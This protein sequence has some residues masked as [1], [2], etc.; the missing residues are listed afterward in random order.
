MGLLSTEYVKA[1]SI[2][3]PDTICLVSPAQELL[4]EFRFII[5]AGE[6]IDGSEYRWDNVLDIRHDWPADC[7]EMAEQMAKHSWQP[8]L[9]YTCD[10]ASTNSG[11]KIIEVNSFACAGLY[12]CDKRIVVDAV[13]NVALREF[14]GDF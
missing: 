9:V 3:D 14:N 4:G 8:D 1:E 11:P 12:A 2:V 5:A 6:V 7:W 13:N 10:V